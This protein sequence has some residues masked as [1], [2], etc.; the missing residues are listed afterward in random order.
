[1]GD[2]DARHELWNDTISNNCGKKLQKQTEE[3][4]LLVYAST[5][6]TKI[7]VVSK[8]RYVLDLTLAKNSDIINIRKLKELSSDHIPVSFSVNVQIYEEPRITRDYIITDWTVFKTVINNNIQIQ[9]YIQTKRDVDN[10]IQLIRQ[11]IKRAIHRN[12][13][14]VKIKGRG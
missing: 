8:S 7:D 6:P 5:C 1:M 13:P 4:G 14:Y 10:A 11:F 2:F 3:S 9:R 12:I